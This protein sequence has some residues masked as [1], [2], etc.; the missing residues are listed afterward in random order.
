[1]EDLDVLSDLPALRHLAFL[2]LGQGPAAAAALS[3]V[4]KAMPR[5]EEVTTE[6]LE[7]TSFARRRWGILPDS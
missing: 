2:Q 7:S 1:M 6:G 4:R 5:L 3:L